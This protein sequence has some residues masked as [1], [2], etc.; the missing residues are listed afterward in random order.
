MFA[1]G[2]VILRGSCENLNTSGAT[3]RVLLDPKNL[4]P[5][6]K[7]K[8]KQGNHVKNAPKKDNNKMVLWFEVDDTGCGM[9]RRTL[10]QAHTKTHSENVFSH[11]NLR[12]LSV[13]YI[14]QELIRV[15]GNL[16][17]KALSKLIP[18]QLERK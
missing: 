4:P 1:A 15:N 8:L 5:S 17:L 14:F 13:Y 10:F 16:F 18:Q 9:Q 11:K 6:H 3:R 2:H 12:H 7:A